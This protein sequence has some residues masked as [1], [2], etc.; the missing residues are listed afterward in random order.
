[1]YFQDVLGS[2]QTPFFTWAESN[3]NE[4]NPLFLSVISIP[5][6]SCEVRRLT[7]ALKS[8]HLLN[9][10]R[11]T[12]SNTV[13][14]KQMKTNVSNLTWYSENC[15][16][17]SKEVWKAPSREEKLKT[18]EVDEFFRQLDENIKWEILFRKRAITFCSVL[19]LL[20][21]LLA[22]GSRDKYNNQFFLKEK[23][24]SKSSVIFIESSIFSWWSLVV[25]LL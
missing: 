3:A 13:Q 24:I 1:M 10:V 17:E 8:M 23:G 16:S 6:G 15:L 5:Y 21:N 7:P 25:Y 18:S 11:G 22:T 14:E 2:G 4:N 20:C 9:C 19:A 12:S